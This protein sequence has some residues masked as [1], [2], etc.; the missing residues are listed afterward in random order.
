MYLD[1][2]QIPKNVSRYSI[3]Y[4]PDTF[5]TP[6]RIPEGQNAAVSHGSREL[7][8]EGGSD[9]G[10]GL[11]QERWKRLLWKV[12]FGMVVV[13]LPIPNRN[14]PDTFDLVEQR[15]LQR[16]TDLEKKSMISN[17]FY[18]ISFHQ[19]KLNTQ[20]FFLDLGVFS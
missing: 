12:A 9:F 20:D 6:L 5:W 15:V 1:T 11:S 16:M 2:I 3:L 19:G 14:L 8:T 4:L 10:Q 13:L 17:I 7:K 18:L